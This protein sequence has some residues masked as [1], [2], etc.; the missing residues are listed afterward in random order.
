VKP[1]TIAAETVIARDLEPVVTMGSDGAT[2]LSLRAGAYFRLN[3]AGAEI[4]T[5][6]SE[7]QSLKTI[8]TVLA[9][10]YGADSTKIEADVT[11][12]VVALA[13]CGL[14]HTSP[15]ENSA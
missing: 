9:E 13:R 4:W 11:P 14:V 5:L 1:I 3:A 6:L 15:P 7:P 10:R 2:M 12:F 8:C